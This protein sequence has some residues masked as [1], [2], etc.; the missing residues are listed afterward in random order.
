MKRS[1]KF[2][3]MQVSMTQQSGDFWKLMF[4][5]ITHNMWSYHKQ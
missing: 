2:F 5:I 4:T 3:G 1:E